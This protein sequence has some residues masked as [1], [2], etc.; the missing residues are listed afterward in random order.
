MNRYG[1]EA[2][3]VERRADRRTVATREADGWTCTTWATDAERLVVAEVP[4]GWPAAMVADAL[5]LARVL[6]VAEAL[7]AA[8]VEGARERQRRRDVARAK[9]AGR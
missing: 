5:D 6:G 3:A 1:V 7:D 4:A 9:A 2:G 8:P